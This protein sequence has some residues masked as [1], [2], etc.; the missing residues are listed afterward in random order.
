MRRPFPFPTLTIT[1]V[2]EKI[3]EYSLADL[4]INHYKTHEPIKMEMRT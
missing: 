1:S 4:V 2:K 3:E